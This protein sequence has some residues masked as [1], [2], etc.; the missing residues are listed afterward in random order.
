MNADEARLKRERA[1]AEHAAYRME[2]LRNGPPSAAEPQKPKL[3]LI[4]ESKP[5]AWNKL[6]LLVL[7]VLVGGGLFAWLATH[8][9][10]F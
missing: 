10:R 1:I 6:M 3:H 7:V 8:D 5:L 9:W 2:N 4:R